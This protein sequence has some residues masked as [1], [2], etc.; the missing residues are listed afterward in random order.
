MTFREIKA[1]VKAKRTRKAIAQMYKHNPD[2][3]IAHVNAKLDEASRMEERRQNIL[4]VF[5]E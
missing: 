3:A 1:A 2:R 4:G 5:A